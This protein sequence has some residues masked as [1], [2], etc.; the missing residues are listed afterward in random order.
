MKIKHSLTQEVVIVGWRP[1]QGNRA[2]AVGSLLAAVPD[3]AGLRYVGRVGS[4]FSMREVE[5]L[6]AELAR[7]ELPTAPLD[8]VPALD[9]RD[10]RWVEPTRVGEVVYGEVTP[11]GR[12]R[13]PRWRGW[14]PDKEPGDVVWEGAGGARG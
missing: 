4:G 11:D 12:L 14:R 3:G 7:D 10:A 1:G 9:A 5:A 8:G 6:A 2:G 13:H